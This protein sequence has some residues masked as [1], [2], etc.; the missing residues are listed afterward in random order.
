MS[1]SQ[2]SRRSFIKSAAGA[3][4]APF[5]LPS[6]IWSAE[7][8]PNSRINLGFIGV[9][10]MNS[11]HLGNFLGRESV[12]VVAVCDVDTNRRENAKKR[13][14]DTYGKQAGTEYKGCSAY[15]DFRELLARKDI[16]AVVIATP[17]H[18]HAYIGI[19]AVRAGKDV[20]GEKPLT[21]NVHEALTLTKA[22]RDSGRIFQTGSQQRSSKEFR[23]AAELVRNGVIG[24]I[25]TIT[26]SF[27]DPAPVYNLPE[28]AA[29][30]GLDWDL[31]CGPG[32]LKPYNS[33]LSPRG[34]H[35]HFP[36]WRDTREFGGGMITDWGAHH[37]DIAQW[38]LGVDESGP[39]EVRA[40]QGK[41][42]KR[43]AQLV[44]ANGVVLTHETGKGVSIYGTEGEIHVNRGKFELILGGKTVHKF[45]DKAVDKGTSLDREVILTEREFLKDAK[46]KL[47]DSKNHH[48]DWLN[49]I[50]TR[51][52][53]IC[54]V[55][56][57]ATTVIS[58]HLMN[59]S[60]YSGTSFKW[61]PTERTFAEGGDPKWLTRDYRGE[62]VV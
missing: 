24:D 60:Y 3:V 16:D 25:K 58:C 61:N 34:V 49:S 13:V 18:W 8:A 27:G 40:A 12:Q 7:T 38:A 47:Y 36:K 32:P 51:E 55:A 56:V 44:Y 23:V 10:K 26:T 14:D 5:I 31:W 1:H 39:V 43:G 28:E 9:G 42:A 62:W 30:P 59:M 22:V 29:E 35:T 15:N 41:D 52:R 4:A 48:D 54:D 37:I 20:Y 19:A 17:D 50:K 33:I 21:H 53:P 57:G 2:P 11:G 46:V 45:F 6:R